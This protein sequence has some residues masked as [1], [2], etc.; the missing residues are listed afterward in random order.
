MPT[1]TPNLGLTLPTP[2]VDTGWGS[3]LNT[4]FTTIDNVFAAAGNGPSVGLNVGSGKTLNVAGTMVVTGASSTID[5][6]AI[7]S[8]TPDS[9]AF[10]TLSASGNI[11]ASG[12][13]ANGVAY[14]NG[15][16]VLTTGSA[17]TFDGTNLTIGPVS[18]QGSLTVWRTST[19]N[20]F[21]SRITTQTNNPG[22]IINLNESSSEIS[23]DSTYSLGANPPYV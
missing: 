14:L 5:G 22:F 3:T 19:G 18:S 12:G 17:L 9:G 20:V 8:T 4:D 2:N 23:F 21:Y 13:T 6:M 1:T 7:G 15:S 11:T 16:K 10:T